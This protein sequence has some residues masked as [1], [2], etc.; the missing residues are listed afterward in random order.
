MDTLLTGDEKD[1]GDPPSPVKPH[2]LKKLVKGQWDMRAG[3]DALVE[4]R[5]NLEFITERI[6]LE[7]AKEAED[8]DRKTVKQ[9]DVQEAIDSVTHPH[10]LIK[11]TSRHLRGRAIRL[12]SSLTDT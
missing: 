1:S 10:D 5:H 8:D 6:W 2:S 12:D 7:A 3:S 9:R 4:L 11:E